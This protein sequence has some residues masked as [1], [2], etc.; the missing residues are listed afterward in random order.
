MVIIAKFIGRDG[1]KGFRNGE[2]YNIKTYMA[3]G[4]MWVKALGTR[5]EHIPYVQLESLLE[6]WDILGDNVR[7]VK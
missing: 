6:N 5:L 7:G 3:D 2:T 1:S 4:M